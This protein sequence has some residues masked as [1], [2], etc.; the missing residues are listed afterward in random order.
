VRPTSY[1]SND[2]YTLWHALRGRVLVEPPSW[3]G[4]TP[5]DFKAVDG[6][7]AE[8]VRRFD[9]HFDL[10][11]PVGKPQFGV[12]VGKWPGAKR[13]KY[14]ESIYRYNRG[15][16]P[17]HKC[18]LKAMVKKEAYPKSTKYPRVIQFPPREFDFAQALGSATFQS[19][20]S[21]L[22][23][24]CSV[25]KSA[26]VA[27][28]GYSAIQLAE[29]VNV[30][31]GLART[32]QA[33]FGPSDEAPNL[34]FDQKA[35]TAERARLKSLSRKQRKREEELRLAAEVAYQASFGGRCRPAS[36]YDTAGVDVIPADVE[37][38]DTSV[39]TA[40]HEA[41][42]VHYR[43]IGLEEAVIEALRDM[44]KCHGVAYFGDEKVEYTA[45]HGMASGRSD[46]TY[47]NTRLCLSVWLDVITWI[48]NYVG[49]PE[50]SLGITLFQ[51][52]DDTLI[53][54]PSVWT[55]LFRRAYP[56]NS[57]LNIKWDDTKDM[58]KAT[59]LGCHFIPSP[60][61]WAPTWLVGRALYKAGF[62]YNTRNA[63][64]Y[65][66]E[67][68]T[69]MVYATNHNPY[70]VPLI[71]NLAKELTISPAPV[72]RPHK[73]SFT[74]LIEADPQAERFV[75]NYYDGQLL[76]HEMDLHRGDVMAS[77]GLKYAFA[78]D[79]GLES[80]VGLPDN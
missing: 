1:S 37:K 31:L 2:A 3:A 80:T 19:A 40:A 59:F 50:L 11:R 58:A 71:R 52:G 39:R 35:V 6:A 69:S 9:A 54:T 45:G 48:A 67:W 5:K 41:N 7:W 18:R 57:L 27:A 49:L 4:L 72:A 55:H 73:M 12:W 20:M 22:K 56:Q 51:S 66:S 47:G 24:T 44:G 42:L 78:K 13:V 10:N 16:R 8:R 53:I 79:V 26:L 64:E 62:N 60:V 77:Y 28:C 34:P 32:A 14:T 38:L 25:G 17:P 75:K 68:L 21:R 76:L 70:F 63:L 46:T 61:G 36:Y 29:A 43:A 15:E 33:L 30:A 23:T 74:T 65:D